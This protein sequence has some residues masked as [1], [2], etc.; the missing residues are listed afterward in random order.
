MSSGQ[1]A[2]LLVQK[3][4]I[5]DADDFNKYIIKKDKEST[6]RVGTYSLPQTATYDDIVKIITTRVE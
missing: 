5:E 3:G 4:L 2:T 1:V 6:I